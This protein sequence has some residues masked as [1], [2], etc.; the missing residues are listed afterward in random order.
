LLSIVADY[1]Y[2]IGWKQRDINKIEMAASLFPLNRNIALGP[3]LFYLSENYPSEKA[4]SV[5]N[6]GL[7]YDPNAVDLLQAKVTYSIML[8]RDV[9]EAKSRLIM[10]APNLR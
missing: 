6:K 2:L 8:G 5:L 1:Q 10:L 7:S 3:S 9:T 4:L